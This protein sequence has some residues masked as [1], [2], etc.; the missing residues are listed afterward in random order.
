VPLG[1]AN[2]VKT[3]SHVTVVGWGGQMNVLKKVNVLMNRE[4]VIIT[5]VS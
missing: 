5:R 4:T 1:K 2:I 3:G